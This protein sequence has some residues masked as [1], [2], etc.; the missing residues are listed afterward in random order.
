VTLGTTNEIGFDRIPHVKG[1]GI[2]GYDPRVFKAMSLTYATTAMGADH[3]AGAAI[4]GRAANQSK[5]YGELTE[6]AV[7]DDLSYELQLYTAVLDSMGCCYFIGPSFENMEILTLALNAMYNLDLTREE[8][9]N[10][11]KN[12]IKIELDFNK[13][14]GIL[15]SMN[16][17]PDFFRTEPSEP[18]GLTFTFTKKDLEKFWDKLYS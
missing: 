1:Q 7:K 16:T 15:K 10:I 4:P 2:S 6:N 3:T 11:G 5:D 17:I 9:I 18:T 14:A 12:I 8:V 13:E